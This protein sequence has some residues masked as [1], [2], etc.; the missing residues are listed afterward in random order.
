MQRRSFVALSLL[1]ASSL[2]LAGR[3]W[4]QDAG[5]YPS[6][7]VTIL[8][9]FAAGGNTDTFAR[10]VGQELDTALGQRF[11]VE[12]KPGAGGNLGVG[13]LARA[14]PD[15]YTLGMGTV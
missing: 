12:N 10:L 8:V 11:L 14:E 13:Q 2:T 4:A 5:D 7:P 9:P 6:K 1:G 15:G 3:A